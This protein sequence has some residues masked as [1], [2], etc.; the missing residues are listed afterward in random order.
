[1][2]IGGLQFMTTAKNSTETGSHVDYHKAIMGIWEQ[3]VAQSRFFPGPA[4][5][6]QVRKYEPVGAGYKLTF[7]GVREHGARDSWHYTANYD[8]KDYPVTGSD[9]V[10]TIALFQ[11][12]A[13][14]TLG[15]FKKDGLEVAMY[16]RSIE[17]DGMMLTITTAGV[18]SQ[19]HPYYDVTVFH[20]KQT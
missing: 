3:D 7:E 9:G 2:N 8:G 17:R 15:I 10:D 13:H 20:K 5:Q 6:S 12:D 16:K 18:S 11:I 14:N 1:M 19:G 4:P